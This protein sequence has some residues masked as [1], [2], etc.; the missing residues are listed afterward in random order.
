MIM[1]SSVN[2]AKDR[3]GVIAPPPL[4]FI[5]GLAAGGVIAFY[6]DFPLL[7]KTVSLVGGGLLVALGLG[8]ILVAW[9]QMVAAKTNIEPWHPTHAIVDTG[10][11]ALSRNPIY[12]AMAGIYLGAT[13][14]VNSFWLLPWLA[15]VLLT[16]HFGVIR[17][18]ERYLEGKFGDA[19]LG[20][21]ERVRR[22]I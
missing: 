15:P 12:L 14:L 17:R 13:L 4:I 6:H 18:E 22:W 21:K 1:G 19:Y 8:V 11:Y 20:Y 10:V 7:P 5:A 2:T 9:R 3:P 16:M